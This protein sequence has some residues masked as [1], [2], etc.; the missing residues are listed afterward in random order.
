MLDFRSIERFAEALQDVDVFVNNAGLLHQPSEKTKQ[1]FDLVIGTNY[2]GTYYL[3][4][5]VLPKLMRL[6]HDVIYINTISIIHKIAHVDYSRFHQSKG[7][8][9][10]S[11]LCLARYTWSLANRCKG[12]N[13]HVYM[14]HPGMAVTPIAA[15]IVGPLYRIARFIPVNSAEK[16][17]LSVAWILSHMVPEG[18]IVG[19]NRGFGGWGYPEINKPCRRANVGIEELLRFSENEIRRVT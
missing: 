1:G 15:H 13:V 8:Y 14:N 6:P 9:A 4:E 10:R 5:T 17:S 12:T 2:L 3:T 19:P 16:S 11:K 7:A 18:A